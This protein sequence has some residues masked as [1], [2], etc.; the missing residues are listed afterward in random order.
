M[1]TPTKRQQEI[2]DYIA[3]E[4][5]AGESSSLRELADHFGLSLST[6]A[7]HIR[8]LK[9]KG[10]ITSPSGKARSIRITSPLTGHRGAIADIPVYGSIPAGFAQNVAQETEGRAS[11]DVL[12]LGFRPTLSTFGLKVTGDSMVGKH[13]LPG[14]IV[15]VEQGIEPRPNDVVA[16]LIDQESTL[17]TYTVKNGKPFLKAENPRYPNLLPVNELV[18]QGVMKFLYRKHR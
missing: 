9:Q 17:K 12:T 4:N 8:L 14:D 6:L 13:I 1:P 7:E 15:I 10:L 5:A 16:A 3:G 18:I 2:M 11:I